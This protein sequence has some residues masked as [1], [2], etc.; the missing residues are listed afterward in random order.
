MNVPTRLHQ[1]KFQQI[2]AVCLLKF[3]LNLHSNLLDSF[4]NR[5]SL[6]QYAQRKLVAD[7]SFVSV[8]LFQNFDR[9]LHVRHSHNDLL[10]FALKQ[11]VRE[12]LRIEQYRLKDARQLTGKEA[13]EIYTVAVK[14]P[15]FLDRV[16]FHLSDLQEPVVCDGD[17]NKIQ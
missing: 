7:C 17:M 8:M 5:V 9:Y 16:C 12:Q 10:M 3:W 1:R 11:L 6:V 14:E 15:D 13:L 2:I 4:V